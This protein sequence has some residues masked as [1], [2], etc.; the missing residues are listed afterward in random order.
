MKRQ[1]LAIAFVSILGLPSYAIN[2]FHAEWKQHY[3]TGNPNALFVASARKAGCYICHVKGE[4]KKDVRNEY[5][6]ALSKHLDADEFPKAWVK[7]NPEEAKRRIVAA[8]K[9][10]E[11]DQSKD[12]E[13]FGQKI[14]AGKL[15]AVDSGH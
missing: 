10:V 5:G 3:L 4:S 12:N 13:E 2:L 1:A 9:N 15:P 7:A 14:R 11:V 6:A 8:F